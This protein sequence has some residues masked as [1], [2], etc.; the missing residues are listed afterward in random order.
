MK[1]FISGL[2]NLTVASILVVSLASC[3]GADERKMKYLEKGKSYLAEDNYEKAKIEIKNVLQI[4]P[5]FAEAYFLMGQLEEKK[6]ELRKAVGNYKKAIELDPEYVEAKIKLSKIY[7]IASTKDYIEK[8]KKLL[9]EVKKSDPDNVEAEFARALIVFKVE[10]KAK[11]IKLLETIVEKD[12]SQYEAVVLL[13]MAYKSQGSDANAKNILIS[14]AKNN[15]DNIHI[16]IALAKMMA[17]MNEFEAAEEHLKAAISLDPEKYSLQVALSSIYMASNN[18]DQAETVLRKAIEDDDE[19]VQRYIVLVDMLSSRVSVQKAED[20]LNRAI[21]NKPEMYELQFVL[22]EFHLKR[23]KRAEAQSILEGIAAERTNDVEGV[24]ARNMLAEILFEDGDNKAA[25]TYI[26]KI[27]AEHPNNNDALLISSKLA[28][29]ASDAISAINSLRTVVKNDPKNTEAS[30]LLAQAHDQNND[31][32]L[33]E[34]ELKRAIEANPINDQ[35]HI[36]YARYLGSVGRVDEMVEVVDKALA[37]FRDSYGLM[38]IKLKIVA[39]Q[40]KENE[41]LALLNSMEQ[42]DPNN[43]EVNINRGQFYLSKRNISMALEEFEKA[44]QKSRDKYKTLQLIVKTHVANKQPE[45]ALVRLQEILDKDADDPVANLLIGQVYMVQKKVDEARLKFKLA[46]K[47]DET[48][49]VPYSSLVASYLN[50][51]NYDEAIQVLNKAISKVKNKTFVQT[52]IASIYEKQKKYKEAMEIYK[53]I[54]DEDSG[55]KIVINNYASL[56]LDFGD[57]S[58]AEKA[59]ELSKVFEQAKQPALRDTLGWAYAKSNNNVKAI[60]ILKP[61]VD[62]SPNIAVFRYHLGTA[63]L[64]MGDKSAAKSHLQIAVSSEQEFVGKEAAKK[65]LKML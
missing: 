24:K 26:D 8:A 52:Q 51:N 38:A 44:H 37:Y 14:G 47:A 63:L 6:K 28:L 45:K 42:A 65:L 22:A 27:L 2:A 39:S 5:K 57:E 59:L 10:D 16:R 40:G 9:S 64:N 23:G 58:D 18:L 36:N 54:L 35:T 29:A 46:S 41:V 49:F 61:I 48:W 13:S 34:N 30:V 32:T 17:N 15:P 1:K 60:E 33:A 12:T 62:K 43:A 3:G 7:I 25:K 55:N 21:K 19:D 4:D 53:K 20:E 50:D 31:N 56:L 11:G